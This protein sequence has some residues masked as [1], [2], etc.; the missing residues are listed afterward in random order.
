MTNIGNRY[1]FVSPSHLISKQVGMHVLESHHHHHICF[2]S[3]CEQKE[4]IPY[5]C[6]FSQLSFVQPGVRAGEQ[7]HLT[8]AA[9][10]G[11]SPSV[12]SAVRPR[13]ATA[14]RVEPDAGS[15]CVLCDIIPP[16]PVRCGVA[17][18]N[19]NNDGILSGQ[20]PHTSA[21]RQCLVYFCLHF[22]WLSRI[23]PL[24]N[25]DGILSSW[26]EHLLHHLK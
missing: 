15:P 13:D 19:L 14:R 3:C 12:L 10:H 21:L 4:Y 17:K 25:F 26:P 16:N 11:I 1:F 8:I 2:E 5:T 22:Y 6:W 18:E 9:V 23:N 20:V 7:N 24:F